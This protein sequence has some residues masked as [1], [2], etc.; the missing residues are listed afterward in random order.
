MPRT[1]RDHAA[2]SE[3][4]FVS[5][6]DDDKVTDNAASFL[7]GQVAA[8]M[9]AMQQS[10]TEA[11]ERLLAKVLDRQPSSPVPPASAFPVV[12]SGTFTHCTARFGGDADE[13]VDAFIDAIHS[14]KDCANV[15]EQNALRGL[16]VAHEECCN[17]VSGRPPH[18]IYRELFQQQQGSDNT[19]LFVARCRALLSKIPPSDISE[20]AQ[21]D[22]VYGLLDVRIRKHLRRE[23]F[24]DFSSMLRLARSIEIEEN[25]HPGQQPSGRSARW[26]SGGAAQPAPLPPRRSAAPLA[27]STASTPP[28][29]TSQQSTVVSDSAASPRPK[30]NVAKPKCVY[31]KQY[32]HVREDCIKLRKCSD[33]DKALHCY[34]CGAKGVLRSQCPKCSIKLS[35]SSVTIENNYA[36]ALVS[37]SK[38]ITKFSDVTPS[39][40]IPRNSDRS[41]SNNVQL[42]K[43]TRGMRSNSYVSYSPYVE[44]QSC[45][46]LNNICCCVIELSNIYPDIPIFDKC[47]SDVPIRVDG[48][49]VDKC[50]RDVPLRV[51]GS[52]VDKCNSDVPIRVEDPFVNK[53][54]SDVLVIG[55]R[56]SPSPVR[57]NSPAIPPTRGCYFSNVDQLNTPS[58]VSF[59]CADNTATTTV[60]LGGVM[61]SVLLAP[62]ALHA[63]TVHSPQ[64]RPVLSIQVLGLRGMALIDTAANCSIA[65][66]KLY[67]IFMEKGLTFYT[68][69]VNV[70][71]ADG[72]VHP[73]EI[74]VAG[75]DVIITV[76]KSVRVDFIIFLMLT[77]TTLS[78]ASTSSTLQVWFWISLLLLGTSPAA[79]RHT[80]L[81]LRVKLCYDTIQSPCLLCR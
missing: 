1:R 38:R 7:S 52:I 57:V 29:G 26:R 28:D 43:Q 81:S 45:A 25:H 16:Y 31:C 50:N 56:N 39:H 22:M 15:S 58:V 9:A 37:K 3:D 78:W 42:R 66:H 73:R 65:G 23:D 49:I 60:P 44:S 21:V 59:A 46:C 51:D 55:K 61:P 6:A 75:V 20:K 24:N 18:R 13:S 71:L 17:M 76:D 67:K 27:P 54:Y 68:K 48:S 74:L 63:T 32:G 19:D 2:P 33:N 5:D 47:N 14:Y 62:S 30:H 35:F 53:C 4:D 40:D 77:I 79:R 41:D 64:R 34:G 80:C 36:P 11:F 69:Q 72:V 8:M 12:G 70:K 10:Q